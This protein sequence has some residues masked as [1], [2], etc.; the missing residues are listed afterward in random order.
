MMNAGLVQAGMK[1]YW[2]KSSYCFNYC[3]D[4]IGYPTS[5]LA[6]Q[7]YILKPAFI[8]DYILSPLRRNRYYTATAVTLVAAYG[9]YK[10]SRPYYYWFKNW[11]IYKKRTQ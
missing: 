10:V 5:C 2:Y 4:T 7:I 6:S 1:R 3:A 8:H 11:F 9:I